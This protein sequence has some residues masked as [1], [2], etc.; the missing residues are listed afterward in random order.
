M[1]QPQMGQMPL[2]GPMMG[3]P[4][5]PTPL[6]IT[7]LVDAHE[8]YRETLTSRMETDWN[9]VT[10]TEF[11]AGDGYQS[12]TSNEPMTS[13]DK[14]TTTLSSGAVKIRIPVAKA[15]RE[16]RERESAKERFLLGLLKANDERLGWLGEQ[17][18]LTTLSAFIN[19]RG[20]YCGR[21]LLVKDENT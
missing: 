11:D 4:P 8:R 19:L 15:Q 17:S 14:M 1:G 16:K 3:G 21:C 18:L 20:W 9:L 2:S 10:L 7:N 6:E 5:I 12:Y 13:Y